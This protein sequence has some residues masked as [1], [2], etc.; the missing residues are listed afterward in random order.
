MPS[1]P[2]PRR[3]TGILGCVPATFVV[4]P[5][6]QSSESSRATRLIDGADAIVGDLPRP[7]THV[8]EI[9]MEAGE[10]LD[11]GIRRYSS[12]TGIRARVETEL[13]LHTGPIVTIGGSCAADLASVMHAVTSRPAGDVALVWLDAHADI[14]NA[15][16]SRTGAFDGMV[17]R[18]LLGD[19]PAGLAPNGGEHLGPGQVILAGTRSID[20]AESDYLESAGIRMLAIDDLATPD[21]LLAAIAAS[22]AASV[23]L[24]VDLDVLDPAAIAGIARPEP[25]GL[26]PDTLCELIR[27]VRGRF[28]TAGAAVTGFAPESAAAATDDLATILRII[29]ALTSP[30]T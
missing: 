10:P 18:A 27:A 11:T 16:S 5:Q 6:W 19:A 12:L 21:A 30:L 17:V 7:A 24:H 15:A 13:S 23:Y 26:Q 8:V 22:G 20:D 9:P 3:T 2:S 4:V 29:G 1:H 25:F 14:H 28:E